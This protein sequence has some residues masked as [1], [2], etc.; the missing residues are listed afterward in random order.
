MLARY[1]TAGVSVA[2]AVLAALEVFWKAA[3][4]ARA[5][6]AARA[7][8]RIRLWE[9]LGDGGE[10]RRGL[11][12][13]PAPAALRGE[14]RQPG[15]AAT[16]GQWRIAA[17]ALAAAARRRPLRLRE[18]RRQGRRQPRLPGGDHAPRAAFEAQ[19]PQRLV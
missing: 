15:A 12:S 4:N 11:A 18:V 8:A 17:R 3:G 19:R 13:A 1:Q 16:P 6:V 5:E 10:P 9:G 2:S 14:R 7:V